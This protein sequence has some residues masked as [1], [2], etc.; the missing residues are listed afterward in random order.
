M[1][2]TDCRSRTQQQI[3]E[4]MARAPN[5]SLTRPYVHPPPVMRVCDSQ[6]G[7]WDCDF[8]GESFSSSPPPQ[9]LMFLPHPSVSPSQ[10]QSQVQSQSPPSSTTMNNL[11]TNTNDSEKP[12]ESSIVTDH[13][14]RPPSN[15]S[16][17]GRQ[18]TGGPLTTTVGDDGD[19]IS[20][21]RAQFRRSLTTTLNKS[22]V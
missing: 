12:A 5:M 6:G 10:P 17:D 18:T 14:V 15:K 11:N 7:S 4:L 1:R 9:S 19:S 16:N 22:A 3:S 8:Y 21:F 2:L 20:D 13:P